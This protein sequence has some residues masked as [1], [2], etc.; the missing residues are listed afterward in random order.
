MARYQEYIPPQG[1]EELARTAFAPIPPVSESEQEYATQA[2]PQRSTVRRH[3]ELVK[4]PSVSD[5]ESS[6]AAGVTSRHLSRR[7]L[8]AQN[9]R[10]PGPVGSSFESST[11]SRRQSPD[12][13]G[14]RGIQADPS[15]SPPTTKPLPGGSRTL[16]RKVSSRNIQKDKAPSRAAPT[17][18][19]AKTPFRRPPQGAG[20]KV[21]NIA[22]HFERITRDNERAN[23]RYV[24]IRGR[25]ARPVASARATVEVLDS[26]KDAIQDESESSDSSSEADDEGGD[27]DEARKPTDAIAAESSPEQSLTLP[28]VTVQEATPIPSVPV[29]DDEPSPAPPSSTPPL[30][31]PAQQLEPSPSF[32]PSPFLTSQFTG[33]NLP[34]TPPQIDEIPGRHSLFKQAFQGLFSTQ[35]L[36]PRSDPE[37]E[38][39]LNDPEHIFRD[40]SMVVRTDEPTSIIA[41]AL[42]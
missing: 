17:V 6:Y 19:S 38:D 23:R 31:P 37:A 15:T 25:K 18:P 5:F 34:P 1:V 42:K 39:P 10:I 14:A 7:S 2:P 29:P 4:K 32:P 30:P 24:V 21:S 11:V 33:A 22:R 12:K 28:K 26:I 27:E 9:S 35:F 8:G 16:R 36:P 20:S 13:R 40:S 41:L 3:R